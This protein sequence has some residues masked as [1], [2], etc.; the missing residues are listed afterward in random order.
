M[1]KSRFSTAS[2]YS[3]T[4]RG[5]R[6]TKTRLDGSSWPNNPDWPM[7]KLTYQY[8]KLH[9]SPNFARFFVTTNFASARCGIIALSPKEL[10]QLRE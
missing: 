3:S 9:P 1:W 6:L 5:R 4:A 8:L 2:S 7:P 10:S